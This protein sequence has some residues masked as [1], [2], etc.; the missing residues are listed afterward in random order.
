MSFA[1]AGDA[2]AELTRL[3]FARRE[4]AQ[5]FAPGE[6]GRCPASAVAARAGRSGRDG[7]DGRRGGERHHGKERPTSRWACPSTRS[8]RAA[9]VFVSIALIRVYP[10]R[11]AKKVDRAGARPIGPA[12]PQSS[13]SPPQPRRRR[14]RSRCR[15]AFRSSCT[16]RT[17]SGNDAAGSALDFPAGHLWAVRRVRRGAQRHR[18]DGG[19]AGTAGGAADGWHLLR[20]FGIDIGSCAACDGRPRIRAR[21]CSDHGSAR[22]PRSLTLHTALCEVSHMATGLSIDPELLERALELSGERT[23]RAAVSR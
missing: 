1:Q 8:S 12:C 13:G 19:S 15:L 4:L 16:T 10:E 21:R 14:Q 2:A 7:R 5:R 23:E 3:G 22:G 17:R 9:S 11:Q 18:H 6:Q 20:V